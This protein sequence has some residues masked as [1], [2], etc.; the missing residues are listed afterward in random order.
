MWNR[1]GYIFL[2]VL[3]CLNSPEWKYKGEGG[4]LVSKFKLRHTKWSKTDFG[5]KFS[6][7]WPTGSQSRPARKIEH[8]EIWTYFTLGHNLRL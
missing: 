1:E 5:S 6:L 4:Q 7:V 8:L 3:H 2:T